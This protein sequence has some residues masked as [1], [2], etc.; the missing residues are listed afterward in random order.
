M[1]TTSPCSYWNIHIPQSYHY[2][3][4]KLCLKRSKTLSLYMHSF[5]ST[6]LVELSSQLLSPH[7]SPISDSGHIM[8]LFK[9]LSSDVPNQIIFHVLSSVNNSYNSLNNNLDGHFTYI[10]LIFPTPLRWAFIT[11]FALLL[12]CTFQEIT[13]TFVQPGNIILLATRDD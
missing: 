2:K 5:I 7:S 13:L 1:N 3:Q 6:A 4:W 12:K 10:I 8:N 11:I 9:M